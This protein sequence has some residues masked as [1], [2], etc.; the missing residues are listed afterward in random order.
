MLFLEYRFR[1]LNEEQQEP[2]GIGEDEDI[3]KE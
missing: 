2:Y 3:V 1:H